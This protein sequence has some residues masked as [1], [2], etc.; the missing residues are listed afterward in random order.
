[1]RATPS[2]GQQFAGWTG[3]CKGKGT[4]TLKADKARS[5]KAVFKKKT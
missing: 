5:A 4:C 1:L 3:A 2:A